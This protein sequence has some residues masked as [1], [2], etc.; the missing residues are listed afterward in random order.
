MAIADD[1]G[2]PR[3][4]TPEDRYPKLDDLLRTPSDL[5]DEQ[6]DLFAAAWADGALSGDAL[7]EIESVFAANPSK[8]A[9]A[10]GFR[11]IKLIPG[12]ER[13]S[14]KNRYLK[15]V[16][17]VIAIKRTLLVTLA[18]AAA[19]LTLFTLKPVLEKHDSE[20]TLPRLPEVA[21]ISEAV[22]PDFGPVIAAGRSSSGKTFRS[23]EDVIKAKKLSAEA[24]P[25]RTLI[26]PVE[27]RYISGESIR[28]AGLSAEEIRPVKFIS[29]T[30][31]EPG[32]TDLNWIIKGYSRIAGLLSK[33]EKP[34]DGYYIA[35]ACVKGI[36]N[37]LGWDM[38]LEKVLNEKGE[39]VSVS[40]SSSFLSFSAPVKKHA[41]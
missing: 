41:Q 28:I 23:P 33:K 32:Q 4:T 15:S 6:F 3:L 18:S 13:W 1:I 17:T 19:I 27:V 9:Y 30:S 21:A 24:A 22:I 31:R 40:F 35:N 11:K 2:F 34:V 14:G 10:D 7:T 20:I 5:T 25:E 36:N 16:T 38:D 12:N 29:V 37:A 26:S 8:K 39:P